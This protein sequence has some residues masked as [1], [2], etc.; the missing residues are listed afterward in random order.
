[1]ISSKTETAMFRL[2]Q[3]QSARFLVLGFSLKVYQ[4]W[5]FVFIYKDYCICSV[6]YDLSVHI[7][8]FIF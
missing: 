4:N 3:N 1:M 8:I 2:H 7:I 6:Y 5:G